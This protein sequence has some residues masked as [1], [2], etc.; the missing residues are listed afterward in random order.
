MLLSF[1]I[2]NYASV[3]D[4]DVDFRFMEGKAPNGHK[5]SDYLMFLASGKNRSA[6]CLTFFG[7]NAGGKSNIL[8]ALYEF[9][10]IATSNIANAYRPNKLNPKYST[11]VFCLSF[12]IDKNIYEYS[13][14]YDAQKI[15]CEYLNKNTKEIYKISGSGDV[16]SREDQNEKLKN[17]FLEACLD[18][19]DGT[20]F[21]RN[22]LLSRV[23][24]LSPNLN[25]DILKAF[26][27]INNLKIFSSNTFPY[28][29]SIDLLATEFGGTDLAFKEIVGLLGK[30]D[31]NI[32]NMV[33][34][35]TA[36]YDEHAKVRRW[37]D[38]VSIYHKDIN[39]N[40][41]EFCIF[42]ESS[43][44]QLLFGMLGII[45]YVL[46]KGQ[47]LVIDELDRSLHPMLLQA[48]M[49]MFKNKA[50]NRHNAQLIF[51]AHDTSILEDELLRIFEV[52]FVEN[53]VE[54]GTTAHRLCDFEGISNLDVAFGEDQ[55]KIRKGNALQNLAIMRHS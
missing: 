26:D 13:I 18:T 24:W 5:D 41:V 22:S 47:I 25:D 46:R 20:K 40:N 3:L 2:K 36:E 52:T 49:H 33:L 48:I 16:S 37:L 4:L 8:R 55:C 54:K 50:Y 28:S 10:R 39:E 31:I 12:A 53:S 44:T 21:F 17:I 14:E 1:K 19:C 38:D 34:R 6:P 29:Y 27:Y 7:A 15:H 42:E 23:K 11:T 35:R 9:R 45:L 43:G 51:S 32:S 30:L